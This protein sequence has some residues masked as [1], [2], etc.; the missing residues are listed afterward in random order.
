[1]AQRYDTILF[2]ADRTLF[3]FDRSQRQALREV[4]RRNGIPVTDEL[5]NLYVHINNRLWA[6]FDRGE[7]TTA[8]LTRVRFRQFLEEAAIR[9]PDPAEL[10]LQY[11]T[12]LSTHGELFPGAEELCRSLAPYCREY[13][14]TNGIALSQIGRLKRSPLRRYIRKMYISEELGIRKPEAG[15]FAKVRR[16]IGLTEEQWRRTVIVG[17]GLRSDIL[18]GRNA[19]L[20]TIWYNPR[21]L[22]NTTDI[23]PTWQAATFAEIRGI[24]LG[25]NPRQGA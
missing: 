4:Y 8:E 24:I 22:E 19:N 7:I 2:D 5:L 16:D 15:Y 9:G 11:L 6:R 3:D 13:I 10:N 12:A 14:V 20:D 21:G 1:M 25:K 17:D 18:G 23:R